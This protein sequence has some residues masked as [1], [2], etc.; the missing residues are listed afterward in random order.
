MQVLI[1]PPGFMGVVMKNFLK[2]TVLLGAI[3]SSACGVDGKSDQEGERVVRAFSERAQRGDY[4][5][6]YIDAAPGLRAGA[7]EL[8]FSRLMQ[9]VN[10]RLGGR[11]GAKLTER[12]ETQSRDQ[13][14]LRLL[15][16]LTE[17]ENGEAKELFYIQSVA[18]ESKLFRYEINS[19]ALIHG[20]IENQRDSFEE[21]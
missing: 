17:F 11:L 2:A 6:I 8:E 21:G 3:L 15:I 12:R 16:Y 18:G 5:S 20:L 13:S 10:G 9:V 4:R 19:D 14:P 1:N 7:T